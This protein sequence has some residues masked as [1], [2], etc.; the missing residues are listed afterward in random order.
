[1]S[2]T[3]AVYG[4]DWGKIA[5]E[6]NKKTKM[7]IASEMID[8]YEKS[9]GITIKPYIEEIEVATSVTYSRYLG[10]PNG[11][12]YGYQTTNWDG[13]FLRTMNLAK[14]RT[15]KGLTFVGAREFINLMS[16]R[17]KKFK[18]SSHLSIPEE[19]PVNLLAQRLHPAVQNVKITKI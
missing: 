17:K 15:I 4:D 6:Q 19:Y 7:K 8:Y 1:M 2:L 5:P 9:T 10:T 16:E 18:E 14:E 12:P 13:I 11:T 3:T